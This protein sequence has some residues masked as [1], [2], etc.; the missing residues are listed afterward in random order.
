MA[1]VAPAPHP[2]GASTINSNSSA[3]PL[4]A[5]DQFSTGSSAPYGS[6][7]P[8][9]SSSR[10]GSFDSV[11]PSVPGLSNPY[12]LPPP[13]PPPQPHSQLSPYAAIAE[14]G[15]STSA[16]YSSHTT[17]TSTASTSTK[18]SRMG[19]A[20]LQPPPRF[21][22]HTDAEDAIPEPDETSVVE[23]P[24]MYSERR[25]PLT[26]ANPGPSELPYAR[27]PSGMPDPNT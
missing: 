12:D 13:P 19:P 26:V 3:Y 10:T 25:A 22:L 9:H 21:V 18:K 7:V 5:V 11:A 4:R 15:P 24:P 20:V 23:L 27:P 8:Y 6:L 14:A 16:R 2:Y 17:N 1:D